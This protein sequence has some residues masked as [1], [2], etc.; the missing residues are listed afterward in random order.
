MPSKILCRL[1]GKRLNQILR[2]GRRRR[3]P[4]HRTFVVS[5]CLGQVVVCL[6]SPQRRL[7]GRHHALQNPSSWDVLANESGWHLWD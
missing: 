1:M 7:H 3:I 6:P 5:L 4:L 2:T